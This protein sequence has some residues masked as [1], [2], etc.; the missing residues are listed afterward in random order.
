MEVC[1]SAPENEA[2]N[3]VIHEE[4]CIIDS[5]GGLDT[6]TDELCKTTNNTE[7]MD[8][9]ADDGDR[10]DAQL[11]DVPKV[12]EALS[13]IE[14]ILMD[15]SDEMDLLGLPE[16][17]VDF[18]FLDDY[19]S[20]LDADICINNTVAAES[21]QIREMSIEGSMKED[22]VGATKTKDVEVNKSNPGGHTPKS[23]GCLPVDR[24]ISKKEEAKNQHTGTRLVYTRNKEKK[25]CKEKGTKKLM[26]SADQ[27][28][29]AHETNN[30]GGM[31]SSGNCVD[32]VGKENKSDMA[33]KGEIQPIKKASSKYVNSGQPMHI[34][35]NGE[36]SN[37]TR[38]R[39][40]NSLIH[41][42]SVK[43]NAR[44]TIG[45]SSTTKV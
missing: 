31:V 20:I 34:S 11:A 28:L 12:P 44:G 42:K 19:G 24:E 18:T 6:V 27:T 37:S 36:A 14:R 43:Q 26:E 16:K 17:D 35:A 33:T 45:K 3:D 5:S 2:S 32:S 39:S 23:Q 21:T 22:L 30:G 41:G 1:N 9:M 38:S 13:G 10:T 29:T 8:K 7:T 25:L 40:A 4:C 15:D